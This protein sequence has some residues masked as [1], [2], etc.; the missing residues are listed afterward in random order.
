MTTAEFFLGLHD[1]GFDVRW[2]LPPGYDSHTATYD[3]DA[4]VAALRANPSA[5]GL[6]PGPLRAVDCRANTGSIT[7]GAD[8]TVTVR[9]PRGQTVP[10]AKTL[11]VE[12]DSYSGRRNRI[13]FYAQ[14]TVQVKPGWQTKLAET[15]QWALVQAEARRV[16]FSERQRANEKR[17][18]E[19]KAYAGHLR[20]G[21]PTLFSYTK[22]VSDAHGP[23][24][25]QV[26]LRLFGSPEVVLA[27][28]KE[29][30]TRGATFSTAM[31]HLN[32][33]DETKS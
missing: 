25:A 27:F 24:G 6:Y 16:A 30:E 23:V 18:D 21:R 11:L 9:L 7:L 19:E 28:V 20:E 17:M 32:L 10:T 5:E 14:R 31:I 22:V 1:A 8:R 26:E 29:L 3:H 2:N 12:V 13:S 15:V 4:Y 33:S